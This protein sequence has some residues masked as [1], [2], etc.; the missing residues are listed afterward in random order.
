LLRVSYGSYSAHRPIP[1]LHST[2]ATNRRVAW[3]S[4]APDNAFHIAMRGKKPKRHA[5]PKAL[6]VRPKSQAVPQGVGGSEP[7]TA[8]QEEANLAS[9]PNEIVLKILADV[10]YG[11]LLAVSATSRRFHGL[12]SLFTSPGAELAHKQLAAAAFRRYRHHRLCPACER[13][14]PLA[15]FFEQPAWERDAGVA[16]AAPR[17][18]ACIDGEVKVP[19]GE[20]FYSRGATR[21]I[22]VEWCPCCRLLRAHPSS[23][24]CRC[25]ACEVCWTCR[26]DWK[27]RFNAFCRDCRRWRELAVKSYERYGYPDYYDPDRRGWQPRRSI[28]NR[29]WGKGKDSKWERGVV[30]ATSSEARLR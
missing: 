4:E 3:L 2:A 25:D 17:C 11:D 10:E 14:L 19:R 9:L 7:S 27:L 30:D 18:I 1:R 15:C 22:T 28:M 26:M 21:Y 29:E 12:A 13:L 23:A 16:A 20:S 8:A 24:S 6:P 5:K